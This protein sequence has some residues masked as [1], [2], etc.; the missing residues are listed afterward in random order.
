MFGGWSLF[1]LFPRGLGTGCM[2]AQGLVYDFGGEGCVFRKV[3]H[4]TLLCFKAGG[5]F[6]YSPGK[7]V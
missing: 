4:V 3:W 1:D 6:T 2:F 5:W 7:R